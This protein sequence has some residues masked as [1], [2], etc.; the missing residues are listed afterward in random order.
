VK[1]ETVARR[2]RRFVRRIAHGKTRSD[3]G[4]AYYEQW[5]DQRRSERERPSLQ[6]EG[7]GL[8]SILTT[9]YDTPPNFLRETAAS[10]LAQTSS[11]FEWIVLDNGSSRQDVMAALDE[12]TASDPRIRSRRVETNLGILG[13]MRHCLEIAGG[14]Y[15]VPVDSDDTI[16]PDAISLLTHAIY[17]HRLPP[18]VYTDE[19]VLANGRPQA[20]YLRPDWDPVLNLCTSYVFHLCAFRRAEALELGVYTDAAATWCHDWDT[21]HRFHAAGLEPVHVCEV[22]YHWRSHP[23]SSTNRTR[24]EGGSLESQRHVLE[25][26]VGTT[27]RPELFALELFP[28]NRGAPE[29]WVRR[30]R[31]QPEPLDVLLVRRHKATGP[32]PAFCLGGTDY[33]FAHVGVVEGDRN[34]LT[35]LREHVRDSGSKLTVVLSDEL[36]A[37]GDEWPWEAIGLL[38][39]H[40]DVVIV[41][42]RILN[43]DRIVVAG[44]EMFGFGGVVGTPEFG[45]PAKEP[46][47]FALALKQRCVSACH[48]AFFI[49]R[50]DFLRRALDSLPGEATFG[51]LGAWLGARAASE[52]KRV[53]VSPLVS[54]VARG[55]F[56]GEHTSGPGEV[57]RFRD[58]HTGVLNDPRWYSPHF[59][60]T[61][62]AAYTLGPHTN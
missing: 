10:V 28:I 61:H 8:F 47:Y 20:P 17:E 40:R 31:V 36:V 59:S 56:T 33:P 41:S 55:V 19:D 15:V 26:V 58:L 44:G 35:R 24:P 48:S 5:L 32:R 4:D 53:A 14:E 25:R 60:R 3:M 6:H 49:A 30:Q 23:A 27:R 57:E 12:I 50:T 45:R 54:A 39:L 43:S 11:N 46:G 18:F 13:G 2:T 7:P 42:G 52:G 51:F 22:A 9:V 21:V 29:W 62:G 37:D 34:P 16:E 38:E 1:T